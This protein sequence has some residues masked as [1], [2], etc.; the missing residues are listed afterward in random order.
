MGN[1]PIRGS[2]PSSS[3]VFSLPRPDALAV[4]AEKAIVGSF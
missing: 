1:P 3:R 2:Q 4:R